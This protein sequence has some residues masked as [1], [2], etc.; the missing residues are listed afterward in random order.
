MNASLLFRS[1]RQDM[2][3][4]TTYELRHGNDLHLICEKSNNGFKFDYSESH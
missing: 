3:P 1:D 2:N 4:F